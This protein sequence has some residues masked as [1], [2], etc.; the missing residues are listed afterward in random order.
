MQDQKIFYNDG[1]TEVI[2]NAREKRVVEVNQRL[3]NALGFEINI[4]SL[5]TIMKRV[6]E[7]KFF[8]IPPADY[9]PMVVGEGAWSSNLTNYTSFN[10]SDDFATGVMNMGANN[11]RLAQ[12]E[13][14]VSSINI[15]VINWAKE[16]GWS[17]FELEQAARSGNWDLVTARERSRKENWDLGIQK[18]AFLGLTAATPSPALGLLNQSGV[19]INTTRITAP[20][21]GLSSANLSIFIENVLNDYRSN[22][23]RTAWPTHFVIPESDYLGLAAPSSDTYPIKSKMQLMLETFQVMTGNRN[24]KLLPCAYGDEA[25]NTG[26]IGKQCYALYNSVEDS[27]R[28][29]IP[30]DYTNS[31]ANSINNFQFQNVG[32]GQFT[33]VLALRPTEILYYQYT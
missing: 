6:I 33:G 1:K 7:Q 11:A 22:C 21:S 18:V 20:L 10:V 30:V 27:L 25:Y 12:V 3:A 24:F 29:S 15:P 28:M 32:Y 4:T 5:T 16:L 19:T 14:A 26:I 23:A 9:I 17:L 31:L 8:R 13:A 2:L